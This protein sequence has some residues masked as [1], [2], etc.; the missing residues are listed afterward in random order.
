MPP[1]FKS[2][3]AFRRAV[4]AALLGAAAAS[5]VPSLLAPSPVFA[6]P[7]KTAYRPPKHKAGDFLRVLNDATVVV[8]TNE[9]AAFVEALLQGVHPKQTRVVSVAEWTE[10]APNEN[11]G[12]VRVF[13]INR[14]KL[15]VLG[16][17][18]LN[19]GKRLPEGAAS[20]G[21]LLW[22]SG[23]NC[24]KVDNR[25]GYDIVVSAPDSAWLKQG[26]A[27]FRAWGDRPDE[28]QI[29]PV[30]SLLVVASGGAGADDAARLLT[31]DRPANDLR[32]R[33]HAVSP[34]DWAAG[35]MRTGV[36]DE[37]VLIDR[38]AA[39]QTNPAVL[40]LTSGKTFG[41]GDTIA[42]REPKPSGSENAN[43]AIKWRVVISAP[44]GPMLMEALKQYPDPRRVPKNLTVLGSARDLR[45]VR[46]VAVAGVKNKAVSADLIK[47]L[48]SRTATEL[49]TFDAFEVP[50]RAGLSEILSE[51]ALQQAGITKANDRARVQQLAAADAL[52]IVEITSA[53]GR[54][55]YSSQDTR[56]TPAMHKPPRK[57]LAPSRL[58][59]AVSLPG[60]E[61]DPTL[62]VLS[63][64]LLSRSIGTK[65]DDE[66][67]SDCSRYNDETLPRY[68][69]ALNEYAREKSTRPVEW[70]EKISSKSR[71]T[72]SG[73]LRL[74][75]LTDGLVLWE[76]PFSQTVENTQDEGEKTVVSRG[77]ESAAPTNGVP[78]PSDSAPDA[79][80]TK[81]AESA[82]TGAVQ[83]FR[84]SALLPAPTS[85]ALT[86]TASANTN[87][88]NAAAPTGKLLDI[89]GES[90]LIGL[91]Q[92]DGVQIGDILT[93]TIDNTP[94]SFI[95]TRA[96]PR[97]CDA[98]WDKKSPASL[99]GKLAVG[100]VL[101]RRPLEK[102]AVP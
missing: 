52:L 42:W 70:K 44:N 68:Q 1:R 13:L 45:A 35:I 65:T 54:T 67:Q 76:T 51:I 98:V 63:E 72:V 36:C 38:S 12:E 83:N 58:K 14:E 92:T 46:R 64:A 5:F 86:Q 95:V 61:D 20:A 80:L 9:D 66:Y 2:P 8:I 101:S 99:L 25:T 11:R 27:E 23:K 90:Y 88:A 15:P 73:S 50:D 17:A 100:Q 97:T 41:P 28:P 57:P 4:R 93:L 3:V 71:V 47:Q 31:A 60:K 49:R 102:T 10:A 32:P 79:L 89:D 22:V 56:I 75:D 55:E 59:F 33:F 96:R 19:I 43:G 74:V 16:M 24:G 78:P 40:A 62:R 81:C 87:S 7:H 48:S 85:A 37:I 69:Q 82:I 30:A 77:E 18:A 26:I 94:L 21:D 84:T 6:A 39:A 34:S 91:G 29:R 53:A